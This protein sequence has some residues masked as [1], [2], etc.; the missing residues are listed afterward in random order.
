M[1]GLIPTCLDCVPELPPMTRMRLPFLEALLLLCFWVGLAVAT[2]L[3]PNNQTN[4][5]IPVT[6]LS[7]L[8]DLYN[9]TNGEN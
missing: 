3:L 5:S 8:Y 4:T 7:A 9:A 2:P 1:V 6:E